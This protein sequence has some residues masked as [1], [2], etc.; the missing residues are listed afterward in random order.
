[1]QRPEPT[2]KL[3][4]DREALVDNWSAL[5]RLSDN[6]PA[7]AAVKA[8]C[9]GLG[10]EACVPALRDAG[11]ETFYVAHWSEVEPVIAHIPSHQVAVL[12]GPIRDEDVSYAMATGTVPVI[13]SIEQAR[14]WHQSGG[15]VCHLMVDTGINRLG[16]APSQLSDPA[17]SKLSVDVLMSHLASADEDGASNQRQ[18]DA[19]RD[20]LPLVSH[21]RASLANSAGIALGP[22]FAFD[23]TRPGVSL[24]GGVPRAEL[25]SLIGQVVHLEAAVMQTRVLK[26]GDAVGYNGEFVADCSLRVGTVSLGYADGFLRSC[27]PG[28]ALMAGDARLPVLGKVSMDMIVVDLSKA[29]HVREGDWLNVPFDLPQAARR[30][31]LSQYELLTVL[32]SR[33]G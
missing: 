12:H 3:R 20:C 14:R 26:A 8:N 6:A 22:E 21:R 4:V 1:M 7:G 2:L 19:F 31:S 15:G 10:I 23:L 32:G 9:Y 17:I 30:S 5:N 29:P 16:I 13:N 18:L 28:N 33:W 24:Y 27:G 11:C 25:S